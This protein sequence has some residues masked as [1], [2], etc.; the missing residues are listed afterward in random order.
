M[1]IAGE[2][3]NIISK[4]VGIAKPQLYKIF[5]KVSGDKWEVNFK[6]KIAGIDEKITFKIPPLLSKEMIKAVHERA[7][8]NATLHHGQRKNKYLLGRMIFCGHCSYAMSGGTFDQK[9]R[10]YLHMRESGNRVIDCGHFKRI[11]A[12]VIE[13]PV[14]NDIFDLFG[15]RKRIEQTMRTA[16]TDLGLAKKLESQITKWEKEI[17]KIS[18]DEEKLVEAVLDNILTKNVI[19]KKMDEFSIRKESIASDIQIAKR[20]LEQIATEEELHG[21]SEQIKRRI[22]RSFLT[23]DHRLKEM[24]F[25]EKRELLQS[26]FNGKDP[27]GRRYGVYLEKRTTHWFYKIKGNF[28]EIV[29]SIK[30]DRKLDIGSQDQ[31]AVK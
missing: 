31:E 3:M 13:G 28:Q 8:T 4:R 2:K 24:S 10:Y 7:G 21:R 20:K 11:K 29:G 9:Y 19:K 16:S 27:E 14:M 1:F 12:D 23:S 30:L 26:L 5:N 25:N 22:E 17:R 15:D 6:S 18:K